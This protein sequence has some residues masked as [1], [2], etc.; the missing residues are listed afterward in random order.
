VALI[1]GASSGIGHATAIAFAEAGA[2]VILTARRQDRLQDLATWIQSQHKAAEALAIAGDLLRPEVIR[3]LA[4]SALAW[5]GHVDILVNNAGFGRLRWLDELEAVHD[6]EEQ[7]RLDLTSCVLLTREILPSMMAQRS[8]CIINISSLAG[9]VGTPTDSVYSAAKFGLRGFGEALGR[10]VKGLG[11]HVCTFCPGPVE[12]EF[13][14]HAGRIAETEIWGASWWRLP[15]EPVAHRIVALATNP[16]RLV[17]WPPIALPIVWL[18]TLF[19]GLMDLLMDHFY[20]R[21]I[22]R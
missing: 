17:V 7:I 11:I 2:H 21:R 14:S 20:V 1:T 9:L 22:R 4:A 13:G 18:N 15:A 12:T 6:I 5:K 8:G 16:R 10:E 3:S 19:P